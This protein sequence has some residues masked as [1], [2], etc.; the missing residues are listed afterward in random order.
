MYVSNSSEF[1]HMSSVT[2]FYFVFVYVCDMLGMSVHVHVCVCVC[3]CV[4]EGS[5]LD[6]FFKQMTAE[7]TKYKQILH[8]CIWLV[9]LLQCWARVP[10]ILSLDPD[11]V[12]IT[13]L[14]EVV[15]H[16]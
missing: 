15:F 1:P 2:F 16:H 9:H 11:R 13:R 7:V 3:V 6:Y 10:M 14:Y 12:N 4:C 8:S 5:N